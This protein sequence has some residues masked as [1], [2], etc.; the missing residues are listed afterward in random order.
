MTDR[1]SLYNKALLYCSEAPLESLEDSGVARRVL[2]AVWNDGAV[3]KVLEEG[4]WNAA[5]RSLELAPDPDVTPGFGYA[6]AFRQPEDLVRLNALS[7]DAYFGR[8]LLG[9]LDEAGYWY[10]D[11]DRIFVSFVSD[12]ADYGGDLSRWPASLAE[13]AARWI[14]SIAAHGF[15]KA[16]AQIARMEAAA[17]RAFVIARGRDAA[18]QPTR[19]L[20]PGSWTEARGGRYGDRFRYMGI[21]GAS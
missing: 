19:F 15:N 2:D 8:P 10:A 20:P 6:N 4:L 12:G 14:A 11:C 9:F 18:N 3:R 13:A 1:L 21:G 5:L 7:T 17:E 16:E